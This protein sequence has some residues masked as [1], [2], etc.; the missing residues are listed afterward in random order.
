MRKKL[1]RPL[2][3][4]VWLWVLAI[5]TMSFLPSTMAR[6]TASGGGSSAAQIA[7]FGID[8]TPNF[9][10][11]SMVYFTRSSAAQYR[12]GYFHIRVENTSDVAIRVRPEFFNLRP[13]NAT[14]PG[15]VRTLVAHSTTA[16][17]ANA[18]IS[19]PRIVNVHTSDSAAGARITAG[20]RAYGGPNG[21][22]PLLFPDETIYFR[23]EIQEHPNR[24]IHDTLRRGGLN[25]AYRINYNILATQVD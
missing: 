4:A 7:A 13:R 3:I 14:L 9:N 18:D 2:K 5:A 15:N 6:F 12:S 16:T 25:A 20:V 23:F 24:S 10:A 1:N 22:H 11:H 8:T 19:V 21:N 17:A